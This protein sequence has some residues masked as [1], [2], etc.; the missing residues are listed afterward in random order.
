MADPKAALI[1]QLARARGLDPAAVLSI[2]SVEGGFNGAVGDQGTSFGPFQLHKGGALPSGIENP[3]QWANSQ[4]GISYAEDAIANV[5]KGLKGK[6]AIAAIASKFERPADVAGEIS[7]ASSRYGQ[8]GPN[9][10]GSSP[11]ASAAASASPGTGGG[12]N[13]LLQL[14]QNL[15]AKSQG[16]SP[17]QLALQRMQFQQAQ[18]S[19]GPPSAD[20]TVVPTPPLAKGLSFQGASTQGEDPQ[21]LAH[22]S[23]AARAAGATA[24]RVNSG[25]R[26]PSHNAAVGGVQNSNHLT[27]HA[28]DGDAFVPGRG[29]VP[30]G[31]LLRAT[32]PKYGLRSGD[33]PG[34]FNGGR[35]P[36]HVDDGFNQKGSL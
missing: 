32:A 26:D 13:P 28:L 27:G 15:L 31:T 24:I 29:W 35:D 20:T 12:T 3:A 11:A 16:N 9:L 5:A 36:V 17:L 6:A 1:A 18:H 14:A 33:Q 10:F 2:A 30:L 4:Q 21:L 25:R 23:A 19:F 22:I 8:F 34:F 7:K